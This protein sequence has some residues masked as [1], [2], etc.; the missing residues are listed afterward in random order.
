MFS[1]KYLFENLVELYKSK[2]KKK[3]ISCKGSIKTDKNGEN[4]RITQRA[5]VLLK[6]YT[7]A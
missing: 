1:N 6:K 3:D 4:I 7:Y 5:D 2:K